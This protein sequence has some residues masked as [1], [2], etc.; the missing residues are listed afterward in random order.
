[1]QA[2]QVTILEQRRDHREQQQRPEQ[3]PAGADRTAVSSRNPD[4]E[5]PL[6][7]RQASKR[8]QHIVLDGE[9][10]DRPGLRPGNREGDRDAEQPVDEQR[11]ELPSYPGHRPWAG[12]RPAEPLARVVRRRSAC[13]RLDVCGIPNPLLD[14][15]VPRLVLAARPAAS[16]GVLADLFP[17]KQE[18]AA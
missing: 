6:A 9:N 8:G 5:Q 4:V 15:R 17:A 13:V 7:D 2:A 18:Q 10:Y 11:S 1:M 12:F 3:C 16:G 14:A